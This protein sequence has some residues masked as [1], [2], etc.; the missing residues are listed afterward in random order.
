MKWKFMTRSARISAALAALCIGFLGLTVSGF[1]QDANKQTYDQMVESAKR[2]DS[3]INFAAL[4]FAFLDSSSEHKD[5][6]FN[7]R[8]LNGLNQQKD[9]Q[10]LLDTANGFIA[11]DFVDIRSHFA[12]ATAYKALGH[13]AESQKELVIAK[14]LMQSILDSGDGKSQKTAYVVIN[15]SEEYAVLEFLGIRSTGQ[16]LI[17][18]HT[19]QT[20]GGPA[21]DVLH[22]TKNGQEMDVYFDIAKFYGKEHQQQ[23]A[24]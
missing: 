7:A 3:N 23:P 4:R 13:D 18:G 24:H 2:G 17:L 6:F 21:F 1:A 15:T 16:S 22:S 5:G 11:Q 10:K 8:L 14:G 12:A 9:Y 19:N 20:S